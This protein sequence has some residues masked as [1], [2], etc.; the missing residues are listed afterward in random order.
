[1]ACLSIL[2]A[3]RPEGRRDAADLWLMATRWERKMIVAHLQS[4]AD[5]TLMYMRVEHRR[6]KPRN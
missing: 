1:L 4:Q 5:S 2:R 6:Q 3:L